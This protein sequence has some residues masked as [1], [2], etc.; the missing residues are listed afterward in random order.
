V[1]L[2][3]STQCG[4]VRCCKT[5]TPPPPQVLDPK[6]QIPSPKTLYPKP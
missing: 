3:A 4:R 1:C 2:R 6:S 5:R